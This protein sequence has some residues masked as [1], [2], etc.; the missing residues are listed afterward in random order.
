MNPLVAPRSL[1]RLAAVLLVLLPL[2]ALGVATAATRPKVE[3]PP[4]T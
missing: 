2:V 4:A 1:H 3:N